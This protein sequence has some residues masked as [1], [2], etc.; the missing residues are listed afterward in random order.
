VRE[1]QQLPLDQWHFVAFTFD[2]STL[3]LYRNGIELAATPCAGLWDYGPQALGIGV[4]LRDETT[5]DQRNA[6]Y[7]DGRLDNVAIFHRALSEAEI[8]L[9]AE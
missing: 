4:K 3:R 9:L 1:N 2:G 5:P 7:W 8:R 6:G